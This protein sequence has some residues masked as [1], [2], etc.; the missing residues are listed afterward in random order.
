VSRWALAAAA[1]AVFA[2]LA[3]QLTMDGDV[4]DVSPSWSPDGRAIV[5]SA[6]AHGQTDLVVM[7][8]PGTNRRQVTSTPSD[9]NA[10]AFSPD[11][12]TIAFETNRDGNFEIYVIDLNG[13]N[14]RRLTT[15]AA[16]DRAPAWSPD[17]TRLVF[18]SD[19]EHAKR[20][21]VYTMRADGTDVVQL[22]SDRTVSAP[23]FSPDGAMIAMQVGG[24]VEIMPVSGGATKRLTVA[25][26]NGMSPTWSP[27]GQ[28]IAFV[29]TR[30][31]KPELY[32]MAANGNDQRPL[33]SMPNGATIAPRW[34]PDGSRI[35][36]VYVPDATLGDGTRTHAIY[37]IEL[38]TEKIARASR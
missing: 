24:D 7:D 35:A 25:P 23:V 37:T 30:R 27:D 32:M 20:F 17:G 34:S 26:A 15:S 13:R 28:R 4:H 36:F 10:P 16:D 33:V 6:E 18:L 11:G 14:P 22:T 8:A 12:R 19:R 5:F 38:S 9:E 29:S 1:I 3:W 2:W 21:D 31:S